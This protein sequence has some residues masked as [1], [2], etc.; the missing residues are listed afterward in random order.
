MSAALPSSPP[1]A[2]WQ[3]AEPDTEPH[4]PTMLVTEIGDVIA[5]LEQATEAV[6]REEQPMARDFAVIALD[7]LGQAL[8]LYGL[9][10]TQTGARSPSPNVAY[11]V[12]DGKLV[13]KE[14]T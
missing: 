3:D 9:A 6:E 10:D 11:V 1:P 5:W 2:A 7:K 14:G 8:G 13:P 12:K 4:R